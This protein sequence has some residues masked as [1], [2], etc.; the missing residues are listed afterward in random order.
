MLILI[1]PPGGGDELQGVKKGI[2]EVAD[3]LI[4]N[5]SSGSVSCWFMNVSCASI[6]HFVHLVESRW[7]LI[8][9]S[10]IDSC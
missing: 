6:S 4:V 5:V 7:K 8:A 1:V 3:M 10:K 2:M 9:G